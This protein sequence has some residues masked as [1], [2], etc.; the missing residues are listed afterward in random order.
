MQPIDIPLRQRWM[1][2]L[3]LSREAELETLLAPH[4]A[5]LPEPRWLRR[6]QTGLVMLR[7]RT[8]GTGAQ[9]NAGEVSVTRA[10][11]AVAEQVG[12]AYIK[13]SA[14]HHAELAALADALLQNNSQHKDLMQSVIAPLEL[15]IQQRRDAASRAAATS[16][17]EFFTL[18]RGE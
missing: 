16:K 8:G 1:R 9:F 11:V 12:H 2:T 7:G 17:V 13:G 6:P 4:L 15:A 5:A 14:P 10:S 18:V 3:A